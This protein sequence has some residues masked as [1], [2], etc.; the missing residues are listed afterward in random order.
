ME[1]SLRP[2]AKRLSEL[3]SMEVPLAADVTGAGRQSAG[4][5]LRPGRI[6]CLRICVS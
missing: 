4:A 3:L 6:M 2:V 5:S 1:Y